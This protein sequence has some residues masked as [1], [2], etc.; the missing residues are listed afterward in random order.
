MTAL[1]RKG[2]FLNPFCRLAFRTVRGDS[3]PS[4]ANG[5]SLG[6]LLVQR[7]QESGLT[8]ATLADKR[9]VCRKTLQNWE[10]GRTR[11]IGIV[12][13]AIRSLITHYTIQELHRVLSEAQRP[14]NQSGSLCCKYAITSPSTSSALAR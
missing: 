6:T 9:G 4:V 2:V 12:W 8:Q 10:N 5:K 14:K 3:P 7:R 11:S 1:W 13:R